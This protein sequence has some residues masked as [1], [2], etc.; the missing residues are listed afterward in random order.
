MIVFPFV[1]DLQFK[2]EFCEENQLNELNA[3]GI[4]NIL[5]VVPKLNM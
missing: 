3:I 4:A 1:S 2:F 5:I